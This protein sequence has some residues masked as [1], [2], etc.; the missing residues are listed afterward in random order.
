MRTTMTGRSRVRRL[1]ALALGSSALVLGACQGGPGLS[2]DVLNLAKAGEFGVAREIQSSRMT[3]D[4]EDRNY[5]LDRL[6]LTILTLADG[7]PASAQNASREMFN[8]LRTQGLNEDKTVASVVLNEGVR[9]WKGEPFEQAMAF[10]YVS[11]TYASTGDWGNARAAASNALFL[12]K[13]FG[14]NEKGERLSTEQIAQKAATVDGPTQPGARAGE[15]LTA[16]G[17]RR[18]RKSRASDTPVNAAAPTD[19]PAQPAAQPAAQPNPT[20]PGYLDQGYQPVE[21]NFALGYFMVGVSAWNMGERGE[22][23]DNFAKAV[24]YSPALADVVNEIVGGRA[25]TVF[26]VDVGRGPRKE[27]YGMDNAFAKFVAREN[28]VDVPMTLAVAGGSGIVQSSAPVAQDLNRLAADHM[29]NNLEDVRSAKMVLGNALLGAA[30]I[31]AVSSNDEGAQWAALG[32]AI[33]GAIMKAGAAADLR[34]AQLLPQRVHV[35]TA[36][37]PNAGAAGAAVTLAP[38]GVPAMTLV[39]VRPPAEA[40]QVQVRYV[41]FPFEARAE[42]WM[43]AGRVVWAH[44]GY[45]APVEGQDLPYILGGRCVRTPGERSLSDY[46]RAGHLQGF[47]VVELENLYREEGLVWTVEDQ[48]GY[49]G[50][51]VLEGG[52]SLVVPQPGTAGYTRLFAG[53]HRAY[54]PRSPRVK[55]LAEQIRAERAGKVPKVQGAVGG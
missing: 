20:K 17:E 21:T 13:D 50:A 5:I 1:G 48:R 19:T 3:A 30:A 44:D 15:N 42:A 16:R 8:L 7:Q 31:T 29:W 46:Q 9:T 51:H 25:N 26:V 55:E 28:S 35:A 39:N 47:T 36:S 6:G 43:S 37:V 24:R 23:T 52:R 38:A 49:A 10:H 33:G 53:E 12:L 32:M 40:N 14:A 18:E 22:A 54:Q 41:R 27:S 4:K 45:D 11:L 34:H 2:A